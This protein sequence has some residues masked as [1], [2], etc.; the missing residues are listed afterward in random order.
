M[1][2]H[3]AK[4]SG[5]NSG[6]LIETEY[7]VVFGQELADLRRESIDTFLNTKKMLYCLF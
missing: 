5:E 3:G 4:N 1:P 7:G 2:D 6:C